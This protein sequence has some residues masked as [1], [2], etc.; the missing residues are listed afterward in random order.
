MLRNVVCVAGMLC[1]IGANWAMAEPAA[2]VLPVTADV[3]IT[4]VR[5]KMRYSNA[6]GPSTVIRQN[7]NWAGFEA[8]TLL[9]AFDAEAIKGWTVSK[10]HLNLYVAKGDFYGLGLCTVLAP[11]R[12]GRTLNWTERAGSPCWDFVRC[13]EPGAEP[14]EDNWWAWPGSAIYSVSWAHP[15]ARYSHAGP[16]D[17]VRA[18]TEDGRFLHLQVPVDPALVESLAI[19][20][21]YGLILTDD[22]GQVTESYSLIGPAYPYRYNEAEDSW[23][24]TNDIQEETLRP[25]LEVVGEAI[26]QTPPAAPRT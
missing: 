5:G 26:D 19:G 15:S 14:G 11:W 16:Q 8:K 7:Q 18:K 20:A 4:S 24:F 1:L 2:A 23:V 25:T 22:K 10:A 21:C 6:L 9:M 17:L 3:G 12:E 13:P